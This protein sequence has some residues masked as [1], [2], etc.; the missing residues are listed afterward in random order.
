[1]AGVALD[2][3][4]SLSEPSSAGP[5]HPVLLSRPIVS[6]EPLSSA[7]ELPD[8]AALHRL[9]ADVHAQGP[10]E[11][12]AA[13][14]MG[15]V[16][17]RTVGPVTGPSRRDQQ[18]DRALIGDLIR[19]AEALAVRCDEL[20]GRVHHLE[21]VLQEAVDVLS[22]DLVQARAGLR[23]GPEPTPPGRPPAGDG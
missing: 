6:G 1:M 21:V 16:R 10:E 14:W 3:R 17:A 19:V 9:W 23:A 13:G 8:L 15:A 7:R 4:H 5:D 11:M 20:A 18:D 12:P 22:E 2:P